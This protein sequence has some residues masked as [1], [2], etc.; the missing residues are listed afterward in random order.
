MPKEKVM[1]NEVMYNPAGDDD[2]AEYIELVNLEE[3]AIDLTGWKITDNGTDEDT[4]AGYGDGTAVIE[5]GGY[6]VITD[7]DT[8]VTLN[9]NTTHLTTRDNAIASYGLSNEGETITLKD[10]SGNVIDQLTYTPNM[11]GN[12]NGR[13]LEKKT[14][15]QENTQDNWEESTMTGGTPGGR[16]TRYQSTEQTSTTTSSTTTTTLPETTTT[17]TSSTTTS[18]T[19][20]TTTSTTTTSSTS[21]TTT[22]TSTT[23]APSKVTRRCDDGTRHRRCSEEKPLYCLQGELVSR[24][25][26]CGCPEGETCLSDECVKP[27]TQTTTTSSTTSTTTTSSTTTSSTSVREITSTVVEATTTGPA[28]TTVS[29]TTGSSPSKIT[30]K[31]TAGRTRENFAAAITLVTVLTGVYAMKIIFRKS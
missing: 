20:T 12:G 18:M 23:T 7:E 21:S 17:T 11:G 30:G 3:H 5:A 10:A 6:A 16:N 19:I 2:H 1:M 31:A 22:T 28:T 13:S 4:L 27:A 26:E 15:D 24:C 25:G 9:E 14:P 29:S 8:N